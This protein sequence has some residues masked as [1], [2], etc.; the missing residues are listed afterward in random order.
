MPWLYEHVVI[1]SKAKLEGFTQALEENTYG[2]RDRTFS[3][4]RL[5]IELA[6]AL[7]PAPYQ[8]IG[9]LL[10]FFPNVVTLVMMHYQVGN[11][12]LL[13]PSI[14]LAVKH[15]F[16][17][18]PAAHAA[19][20]AS[21]EP[22]T[23]LLNFMDGHPMLTTVSF[24][25]VLESLASV[26]ITKAYTS[27]SR[28]QSIRQ[29]VVRSTEQFINFAVIALAHSM[30]PNLN[31]RSFTCDLDIG[32]SSVLTCFQ[33]YPPHGPSGNLRTRLNITHLSLCIPVDGGEAWPPTNLLEDL[34]SIE[35]L[36]PNLCDLE[37]TFKG[38]GSFTFTSWVCLDTAGF[39]RVPQVRTLSIQRVLE[40]ESALWDPVGT[41]HHTL[42]LPWLSLF[43]GLQAIRIRE[44][45]DFGEV[46]RHPTM[47]FVEEEG[48]TTRIEDAYGE[49]LV[50]V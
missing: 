12:H 7:H 33:D 37:L 11:L 31:S 48:W 36:C 41:L 10:S 28:H 46:K 6:A 44:D 13:L 21:A 27:R 22:L 19:S 40:D 26:S 4:K 23:P 3:T 15:L 17:S 24:P 18:Q 30:C 1:D 38:S 16:W 29:W 9:R 34:A 50:L 43:P 32:M 25:F 20:Y 45:L 39:P 49:P 2:V 8:C 35:V 42:S 47:A 5:D 14:P